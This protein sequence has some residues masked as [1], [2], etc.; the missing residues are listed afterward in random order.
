M[1]GP[2]VAC[3]AFISAFYHLPPNVLPTIQMVE[4]GRPGLISANKD[5]STDLGVMQI[6]SG[7]ISVIA[8][9]T[10]TSESIIQRRLLHESCFNIATAGAIMRIYLN[11]ENGNV[12]RAIGNY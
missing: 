9:I 3:F 8:K 5:G 11:E 6:N 7:W 2:L 1:S 10:R 4:G 12:M